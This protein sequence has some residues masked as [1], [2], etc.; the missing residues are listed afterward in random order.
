M[1][2][3]PKHLFL[4][5][6]LVLALASFA[7]AATN[8]LAF[9]AF[10]D[11]DFVAGAIQD[12]DDDFTEPDPEQAAPTAEAKR[13]FFS[14]PP[15]KVIPRVAT[16]PARVTDFLSEIGLALALVVY[17]IYYYLNSEANVPLVKAWYDNTDQIWSSN[18]AAM[19][20][21][22]AKVIKDSPRDY[23]F[24]ATGRMYVKY[25]YG[26]LRF[27]PRHDL[28]QSI[29]E[30][31]W[32]IEHD[33][34]VYKIAL[35]DNESD[36]FVFAIVRKDKYKEI[37][38]ERWDLETFGKPRTDLPNFPH[39]YYTLVTDAPEFATQVVS[40]PRIIKALWAAVGLN[41]RGQGTP[42][43]EPYLESI[44]LTDMPAEKPA[45]LASLN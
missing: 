22:D 34:L 18:F 1:K 33:E 39:Q 17:M 5:L 40:E 9:L 12:E 41:D 2:F 31:V 10:H 4:L 45:R 14:G 38:K 36:D 13:S 15:A 16:R 24:Y 43:K 7:R 20:N 23:V 25:L 8:G 30:Y 37:S 32:P 42:L 26:Y 3:R 19:G 35:N 21:P 28:L 27:K 11:G 29:I 44:E 6:V